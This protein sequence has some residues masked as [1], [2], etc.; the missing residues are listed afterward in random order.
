MMK[1]L[2]KVTPLC[3]LTDSTVLFLPSTTPPVAGQPYLCA[4]CWAHLLSSHHAS[5]ASRNFP[6]YLGTSMPSARGPSHAANSSLI[7]SSRDPGLPTSSFSKKSLPTSET[8][9]SDARVR[10]DFLTTDA[11]DDASFSDVNFATMAL[12]SNK[13]FTSD[14]DQQLGG[15]GIGGS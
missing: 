15:K 3:S 6:L 4:V 2:Y 14:A 5:S 7:T 13:R 10:F 8:L 9:L 11:E 12:L 1:L